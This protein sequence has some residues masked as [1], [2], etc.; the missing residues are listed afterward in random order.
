MA[1]DE[2]GEKADERINL[3]I[4]QHTAYI[5]TETSIQKYYSANQNFLISIFKLSFVKIQHIIFY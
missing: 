5:L 3:I 2:S 1:E 4:H